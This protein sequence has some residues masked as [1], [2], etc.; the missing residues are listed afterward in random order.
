MIT[1][2]DD[3]L[4]DDEFGLLKDSPKKQ[5]VK[6]DEDRLIDAFTRINSFYEKNNREPSSSSMSEYELFAQLCN[7][8][9][10]EVRKAIL[11]PF[12]RF[13]LLG[14]VEVDKTMEDILIEDDFGLLDVES[15]L[16]IFDFKHIPKE[17]KRAEADFVAQRHPISENEFEKY[18]LLFK[19]VH[20]DIKDG[21]RK[22][23]PFSNPE[24]NLLEGN[25][26]VVDGLLCYLE[27]SDIEETLTENK[28]GN[29]VRLEGRT[30]TIFENG[31]KSNML[32]RSLGKAIQKNGKLVTETL[33]SIESSLLQNAGTP[34]A[35]SMPSG[36]VY[37]LKSLSKNPQIK[38]IR[39]LYKIGL[40]S[41]PVEER[42]N[43]A[44]NEATYLFADVK[45]IA[46][47]KCYDTNLQVLENLIHR[48]FSHACLNFDINLSN[49]Q[50]VT[51][52]EWFIVPLP[53]IDEA[54]HMLIN[55]SII[56]YMYDT[57]KEKIVLK[58][59]GIP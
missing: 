33:E 21:K 18:D 30:I 42:V 54:I 58:P 49:G 53:V 20:Q 36:W 31:T 55:G 22:L 7:F 37:V 8:R 24:K 51:P 12:D 40:T 15:D 35:S 26:Y 19:Q 57:G 25:F 13:N 28:S 47:Y 6:S 23:L 46:T 39:N 52:R 41:V 4:N 16:S 50:R 48:F 43:S 32:F 44:A 45:I 9:D 1:S 11:K 29:R 59:V 5:T 38:E 10:N 56:N 27:S 2:L 34:V 14:H 3:I 17:E